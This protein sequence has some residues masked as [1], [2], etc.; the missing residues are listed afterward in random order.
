MSDVMMKNLLGLKEDYTLD[1]NDSKDSDDLLIEKEEALTE[2]KGSEESKGD[3]SSDESDN[4]QD[5][6]DSDSDTDS[7]ESEND[8]D[9]KESEND[10]DEAESEGDHTDEGSDSD[11]DTSDDPEESKGDSESE[12]FSTG[13]DREPEFKVDLTAV[14]QKMQSA[15]TPHDFVLSLKDFF[16]VVKEEAQRNWS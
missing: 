10:R 5:S 15:T 7:S 8:R 16:N 3:S 1:L 6:K 2:D 11:S 13:S 14:Y 12:E 9:E 4:D